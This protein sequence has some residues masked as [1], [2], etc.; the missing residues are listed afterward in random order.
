[1]DNPSITVTLALN[2]NLVEEWLR[3][4]IEKFAKNSKNS[5]S[6]EKFPEKWPEKICEVS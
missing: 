1:M 6:F 5:K 3:F 2:N 4:T